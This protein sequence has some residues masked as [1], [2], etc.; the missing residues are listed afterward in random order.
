MG[1]SCTELFYVDAE[2]EIV[3]V[4]NPDEK[5]DTII[6]KL[7]QNENNTK[8]HDY[9]AD[10]K[11][12]QVRKTWDMLGEFDYQDT[13]VNILF[14]PAI[15]NSSMMIDNI[16]GVNQNQAKLRYVKQN[17]DSSTFLGAFTFLDEISMKM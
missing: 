5:N 7:A 16:T 8:D 2:N 3:Q 12:P 9:F 11:N 14:K 17:I 13:K 15:Q 1:N 10:I 4:L 6:G